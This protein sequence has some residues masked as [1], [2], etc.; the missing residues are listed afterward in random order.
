VETSD[1]SDGTVAAPSFSASSASSAASSPTVALDLDGIGRDLADV[2]LALGRLDA[3]TYWVDE[4]TGAELSEA[5]LA[6]RPTARRSS[7]VRSSPVR[8]SPVRSSPE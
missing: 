5:L 3:G 8:S 4:V 2:E 1:S 7:P 6:E